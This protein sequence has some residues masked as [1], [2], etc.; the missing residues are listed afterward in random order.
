[1]KA[2]ISL[3]PPGQAGRSRVP[4]G[5]RESPDDDGTSPV[6]TSGPTMRLALLCVLATGCPALA[7]DG[8]P[9]AVG[10][11][12]VDITPDGPIVLSGF[13]ARNLAE[14]KGVQI[15]I[16]AVAMAIG[17]DEQGP[18]VL[19]TVDNLGIPDAMTTELAARLK[20]KAGI[21]RERLAVG[22]SHTHS[23]PCLPG[24]APNIFGKPFPPEKQARVDQYALEL[25]DKLEKACL[26]ALG[27]RRPAFLA[28]GKGKVDF[29]RNRRPRGGRVDHALP[30]LRAVDPDGTLR[31]VVVDYACHCTTLR[32]EDNLVS[33]DWAG[34]ARLAI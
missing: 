10:V 25:V 34:E 23:A 28:R 29:A 27:D 13:L 3:L 14:S 7:D 31:A 5:H 8:K 22:S 21:A 11:A 16:R 26:G 17:S 33:P 18:S 32:A 2:G 6:L 1:M 19:L 15:P 20:G 9:I 30:I 12:R 24:V 4:A